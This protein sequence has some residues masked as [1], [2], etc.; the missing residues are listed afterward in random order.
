MKNKEY[1]AVEG[2]LYNYNSIK[3]RIKNKEIDLD[4]LENDYRGLTAQSY[5][6]H[7]QS[8]NKFNSDVE[9]EVIKRD[10][11]ILKLR[12]EI[13]LMKN[14]I[15]KI[16]NAMEGLKSYE[17]TLIELKYFDNKRHTDI[18]D[19]LGFE[20]DSITKIKSRVIKKLIPLLY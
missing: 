1:R 10:E 3:I 4:E 7:T 13:K 9:N 18:A 6:E 8:T 12:K 16:D 15:L 20:V 11:K 2:I 17:K 19:E 14:Q 5:E